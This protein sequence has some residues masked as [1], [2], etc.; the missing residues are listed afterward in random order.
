[1][2]MRNPAASVDQLVDAINS[3]NIEAALALYE[4]QATLVAAP[5]KLATGK[6]ALRQAL[7]GFVALKPVLRSLSHQVVEAGDIA[8]YCSEW[9]LKGAA[10]DGT[11]VEMSGKSTDVLRRQADGS[12]LIAVDNPWGVALLG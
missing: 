11:A 12:W 10:P 5:G 9:T 3:G 1:M 2:S 4:P 6:D 8:L 7:A